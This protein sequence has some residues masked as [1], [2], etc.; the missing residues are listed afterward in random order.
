M[1]KTPVEGISLGRVMFIP[2]RQFQKRIWVRVSECTEAALVA[3]C[4]PTSQTLHIV[5]N[6]GFELFNLDY[7]ITE[8]LKS[9][10]PIALFH[11][12]RL[13]TVVLIHVSVNLN[14][15]DEIFVTHITCNYSVFTH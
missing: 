14:I 9:L 5:F 15:Q 2:P 12:C 4:R 11:C 10:S 13:S 8:H 7:L 6:Y 1:I 3:C